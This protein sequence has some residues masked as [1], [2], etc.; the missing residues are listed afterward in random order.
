MAGA[1]RKPP[2]KVTKAPSDFKR[3]KAKVGGK[4]R[5]PQNETDTNFK[6]A[7]IFIAGKTTNPRS[8]GP[9][10]SQKGKSLVDLSLQASHPAALARQSALKGLLNILTEHEPNQLRAHLHVLVQIASVGIVD[11]DSDVRKVGCNLLEKILV[12]YDEPTLSPFLPL[13][14][15]YTCSGLHSLDPYMRVDGARAVDIVCSFF[16]STLSLE[17]AGSILPPFVG[18]LADHRG[19]SLQAVLRALVKVLVI[20]SSNHDNINNQHAVSMEKSADFVYQKGSRSRNAAFYR[21]RKVIHSTPEFYRLQHVFSS[22]YSSSTRAEE[23]V[24]DKPLRTGKPS[25]CSVL[26]GIQRKLCDVLVEVIDCDSVQVHDSQKCFT[27]K[28]AT[29]AIQAMYLSTRAYISNTNPSRVGYDERIIS[30]LFDLFPLNSRLAVIRSEGEAQEIE[31]CNALITKS[32]LLFDAIAEHTEKSRT[33]MNTLMSYWIPSIDKEERSLCHL[34]MIQELLVVFSSNPKRFSSYRKRFL[35]DL[36]AEYLLAPLHEVARSISGRKAAVILAKGC[37]EEVQL[38]S[39]VG[40]RKL[41]AD[42]T[43]ALPTYLNMWSS[44]FQD[45]SLVVLDSM[46]QVVC[47]NAQ[48]DYDTVTRECMLPLFK[49]SNAEISTYEALSSNARYTILGILRLLGRPSRTVL[50]ELSVLSAME[51]PAD[52]F[53]DGGIYGL[54]YSLRKS[55]SMTDYLR[56]VVASVGVLRTTLA[57]TEN[58]GSNDAFLTFLSCLDHRVTLGAQAAVECG[59]GKALKMLEPQLL[60]WMA[61]PADGNFRSRAFV[62]RCRV[63][64]AFISIILLDL[65]KSGD[66][67]KTDT[68]LQ[69]LLERCAIACGHVICFL[70]GSIGIVPQVEDRIL[71][72]IIAWTNLD[73][74]FKIRVHH[75]ILQSIQE[76]RLSEFLRRLDNHG[77]AQQVG[78]K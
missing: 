69:R 54:V 38:D 17:D 40:S 58:M 62:L 66:S 19:K 56:F 7:P 9:I 6:R 33:R 24:D 22:P 47:A 74:K 73:D 30:T 16:Q 59:A 20:A 51:G 5:K 10:L 26:V 25:F 63:S 42:I 2:G 18:L 35:S 55:I 48:N 67:V 34:D 64:I 32:L 61:D 4:A 29:A 37:L 52:S 53:S 13:L 71:A 78:I 77:Q 75:V 46:Y 50:K 31:L 49:K 3:V 14:V 11:E 68:E 8:T 36:Y 60:S 45:E 76:P 43:A 72:P 15:A 1:K 41:V 65:A 12:K 23:V 44:E 21:R 39:E 28:V 57:Q 27:T 70:V